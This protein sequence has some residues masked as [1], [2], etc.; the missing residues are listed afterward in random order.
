MAKIGDLVEVIWE[1]HCTERPGWHPMEEV[2]NEPALCK[3]VGYILAE[4]KKYITLA[5]TMQTTY[6]EYFNGAQTR[7]KSCIKKIRKL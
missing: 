6:G 5:P 7:I 4:N 3:S 2:N 1:D